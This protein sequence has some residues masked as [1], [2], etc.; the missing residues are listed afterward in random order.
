MM[1]IDNR[2]HTSS[3]HALYATA[4]PALFVDSFILKQE[5]F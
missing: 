4:V 3:M 1:V 5:A 2:L